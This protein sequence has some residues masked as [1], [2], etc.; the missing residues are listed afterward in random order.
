MER[1][2]VSMSPEKFIRIVSNAYHELEAPRHAVEMHSY[3]RRSG[4]HETFKEALRA[5]KKALKKGIRILDLG[6]GA[7]YDLEVL[8]E[9]FTKEEV[10]KIVCF[11]ISAEMQALAKKKVDG[12]PCEFILGNMW[13]AL[14]RGPYDLVVSHAMVHHVADLSAFFGVVKRALVPGGGYVM[15]HEPNNRYWNNK[16]CMVVLHELRAFERKRRN[17]RKYFKPSRYIFKLA[18]ILR[19]A[20]N[21]SL[22]SRINKVLRGRYGFKSEL[23]PREIHRLVDIHVPD[24]T[25]GEFKIGYDGFEWEQLQ[26]ECLQGFELAWVGTVG[27]MGETCSPEDLPQRWREINDRL[28]A[29]YPLDGSNFSAY[30]RKAGR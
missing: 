7:G 5:S 25:P 24:A 29:K 17:R 22:E 30:W 28:A 18:R 16:E 2:G 27:Y 10:G 8:K 6:C 12:Y 23:M 15:G 3:F 14:A 19:L 21:D 4:A 11:D 1:V 26:I 9:V 13:D 20:S